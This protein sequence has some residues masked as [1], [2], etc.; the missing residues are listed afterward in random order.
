MEPK[1]P[2]EKINREILTIKETATSDEYGFD[3]NRRPIQ[4][5]IN[6]GV[7]NINK[8]SGPTS[9]QTSDYVKKI[10]NINKAGH[11]GTLDPGVCGMLPIALGKA[12]RV[13]QALLKAGKE[14]IAIMHL[15]KDIEENKIH[16]VAK[17]FTARIEQ[18]PPRRSAIKRQLRKREV[19]YLN[20]LE[21]EDK[22]VLFQVGCE[23]GTY[24][25]KICHDIGLKLGTKA[26]MAE[27]I[28]TKV[29]PFDTSTMFTLHDL[30]DAYEFYKEGDEK[31]LRKII[32]PI[33]NA[34][35]H[36][37]KI[38]VPGIVAGSLCYGANLGIQGISKLESGIK[39]KELIAV[40][41][42][43]NELVCIGNA[44]LTS[45]EIMQK[46]KGVVLSYSPSHQ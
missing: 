21:I 25:R 3:P 45:E 39:Q 23:A 44:N 43:K 15:H 30:K 32:Q 24:I 28:R 20:V 8:P 12:T 29:G 36:L 37:P 33:E 35:K 38:W 17:Q 40:L 10:L 46:E 31:E 6:Y 7:V 22:D 4:T 18:L 13:V 5:L 41:T 42:L 34:V 16:E 14:Y 27:L 9:H 26:H 1:L 2:F 11:S 19:Y